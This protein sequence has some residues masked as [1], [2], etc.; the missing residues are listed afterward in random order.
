MKKTLFKQKLVPLCV[1][2]SLAVA[3]KVG[4]DCQLPVDFGE[5]GECH[6]ATGEQLGYPYCVSVRYAPTQRSECEP[7]HPGVTDCQNHIIDITEYHDWSTPKT[8]YG[9]NVCTDPIRTVSG[10]SGEY[11]LAGIPDGDTCP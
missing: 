7:S 9:H 4:A 3:L 1:L 10:P 6:S 5:A 2:T 8:L 11:C